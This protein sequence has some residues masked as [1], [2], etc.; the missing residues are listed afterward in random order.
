MLFG[1]DRILAHPLREAFAFQPTAEAPLPPLVVNFDPVL[2]DIWSPKRP[3]L[4]AT[5]PMPLAQGHWIEYR[6]DYQVF[7]YRRI[8][9]YGDTPWIVGIYAPGKVIG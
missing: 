1:E 3:T 8:H 5:A 7:A 2:A 9:A 4:T 6:D